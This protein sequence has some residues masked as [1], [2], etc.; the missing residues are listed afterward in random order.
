VG[1]SSSTTVTTTGATLETGEPAPCGSLGA[2]VWYHF[3]AGAS[4]TAVVDTVGGS[5]NYDTVL[6]AYTGSTLTGLTNRACND[7]YSGLQSRITFACT[8]GTIYRIQLGG[9]QA[10]TGTATVDIT[11]CAASSGPVLD[12]TFDDGV[13]N[14]WTLGGLWHVSSACTAAASAPNSLQYNS[15]STCTFS[16]GAR[17]TGNADTAGLNIASIGAPTL[18]FSTKYV[19]ENYA[20]GAYDVMKVQVQTSGSSTWTTLWQRDSRNADQTA[21]TTVTLGLSSYKST[22]TKV[23]FSFDSIDSTANSY[24]GWIV[25]NVK[26][27]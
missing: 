8:A 17:T 7:D 22:A 18:T 5:T 11:G 26:V 6:A 14:G 27:Q 16:T 20:S 12:E 2:S 21:Y 3:T 23:R 13:A 24:L 19:K 10:A 15:A 25:D 4:G 1:P 9:Y